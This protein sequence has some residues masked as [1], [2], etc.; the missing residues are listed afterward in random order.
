MRILESFAQKYGKH[1][2]LYGIELLNEPRPAIPIEILQQF[3]LD[4][5]TRIRAHA[6]P[7]V[8]VVIHDSFRPL[9][10]K[11]FMKGPS[12]HNVILDTHLYQCF[13]KQ[14][15]PVRRGT[16]TTFALDRK[17]DAGPNATRRTAYVGRRMVVVIAGTDDVGS[18]SLA[19]RLGQPRLRGCA[20]IDL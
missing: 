18:I 9:P 14:A 20:T 2:A 15:R 5:Y 16:A 17:R 4:G 11:N 12:L 1:P 7:D 10:W 6:G 19:G 8:A 3:Y 13:D